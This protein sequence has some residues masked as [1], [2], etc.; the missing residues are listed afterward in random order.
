MEEGVW[1]SIELRGYQYWENKYWE[2]LIGWSP[3]DSYCPN[4]EKCEFDRGP[5]PHHHVS[6]D[7]VEIMSNNLLDDTF[8]VVC[9]TIKE[10][11]IEGRSG[12]RITRDGKKTL[13]EKNI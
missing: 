7:R 4:R 2:K 9:Y 8:T 3:Y 12:Y 13:L 10:G 1:V 11:G 6:D 5:F